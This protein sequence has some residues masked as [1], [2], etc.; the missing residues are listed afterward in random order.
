MPR[1]VIDID[2][3]TKSAKIMDNMSSL[4]SNEIKGDV[5]H[6]EIPINSMVV[7]YLIENILFKYFLEHYLM[8][9]SEIIMNLISNSK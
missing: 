8:I 2:Q 7:Q 9:C 4:N 6:I 5:K 3:D 1:I